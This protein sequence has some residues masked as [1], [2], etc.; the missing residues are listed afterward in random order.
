MDI[1]KLQKFFTKEDL[2]YI[3]AVRALYS[4]A[5]DLKYHYLKTLTLDVPCKRTSDVATKCAF[6]VC[7]YEHDCV[8]VVQYQYT[9]YAMCMTCEQC[10]DII[11]VFICI[12]ARLK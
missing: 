2:H 4:R 6:C 9:T 10:T 3:A 11:T 5:N 8:C 12:K 7:K 1:N